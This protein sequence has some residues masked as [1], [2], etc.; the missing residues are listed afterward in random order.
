[1]PIL[2]P[3]IPV[4]EDL[5]SVSQENWNSKQLDPMNLKIPG[6]LLPQRSHLMNLVK[7]LD[8]FE[9]ACVPRNDGW[10]ESSSRRRATS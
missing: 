6:L 5:P 3:P 9:E 4:T 7:K 10:G 2:N 8:C 1:M